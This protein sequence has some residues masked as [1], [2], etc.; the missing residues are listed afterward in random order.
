M[1]ICIFRDGR[2]YFFTNENLKV[3]DRVWPLLTGYTPLGQFY[4][5]GIEPDRFLPAEAH[6]I[7]D[8]NHSETKGYEVRT[9]YGYGPVECYFKLID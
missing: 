2:P 3:G 9:D 5:T 6:T 7:Q 8:L 4:A 1:K